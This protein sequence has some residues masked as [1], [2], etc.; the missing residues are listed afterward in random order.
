MILVSA[1]TEVI[2]LIR[3]ANP[4]VYVVPKVSGT[5]GSLSNG[6]RQA[7]N[8]KR[9][10]GVT[11]GRA[12]PLKDPLAEMKSLK[13]K[14]HQNELKQS[15]QARDLRSAINALPRDARGAISPE[16][17]VEE[18]KKSSLG[19]AIERL[20]LEGLGTGA[21]IAFE[22]AVQSLFSRYADDLGLD[23]AEFQQAKTLMLK[24][25]RDVVA[26]N[27]IRPWDP[28]QPAPAKMDLEETVEMLQEKV[29]NRRRMMLEA[30]GDLSRV[31]AELT[32]SAQNGDTEELTKLGGFLQ[33]FGQAVRAR[34]SHALRETAKKQL[35]TATH[36]EPERP[37]NNHWAEA[38]LDKLA[39]VS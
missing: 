2:S 20:V 17:L 39:N 27:E 3:I 34:S 29:F 11:L 13:T 1:I 8:A 5:T 16:I 12:S 32:V 33:K 23:E 10:D 19:Q 21:D 30:S 36:L 6:Q 26:D 28:S 24:E 25:V 9:E 35:L 15:E 14:S 7:L 38:F 31:L 37:S 4:G 22:H 18:E